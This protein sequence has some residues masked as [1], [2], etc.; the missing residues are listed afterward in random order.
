MST[1]MKMKKRKNHPLEEK[2]PKIRGNLTGNQTEGLIMA[3][4]MKKKTMK[5]F[6]S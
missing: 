1:I 4:E 5:E 3:I 6:H 2:D